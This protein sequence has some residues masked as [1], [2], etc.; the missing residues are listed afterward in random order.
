VRRPLVRASV[1]AVL[2]ALVGGGSTA[3]AMDKTLTVTVDGQDRVLHTYAADVGGAL[4]GAG[5]A[6]APQDRIEPALPTDVVDGDHIIVNRARKLTLVEGGA[7]RSVWTTAASVDEAL[8]GLGVEAAPSH[9]SVAPSATIPLSG[10]SLQLSIPRTVALSDGTAAPT[11]VTTTASTVAGLLAERGIELGPDDVSEPSS[12]SE[13]TDGAHVQ[14]V[15]NGVGEVV[16]VRPIAP[17]EKVVEDPEMPR[18][19]KVV[20]EKGKPGE[21][22]AIMRVQVRNGQEVRR[23]QVRAGGS[24][25]PTPRVVKPTA[26]RRT[27]TATAATTRPPPLTAARRRRRKSPTAPSGTSWP[28]ARPPATGR[29][30]AATATTVA[31]SSTPAPGR[32]TAA[33]STPRCR[34]RPA[35]SSRSRWPAR[36]AT[37][38]AATAPGRPARASSGCRNSPAGSAAGPGRGPRAGR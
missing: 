34:T 6:P 17:P 5:L 38:V 7:E 4:E 32:P 27:P 29:S 21:Q 14:V 35:A 1:L 18:G 19:K 11:Q 37:T 30:T 16:E 15:R 20:V 23:E 33:A 13:L 8:K 31:C 22:T 9:I 12:D 3:L 25:A 28:S 10:M 2:I 36:S 24:T 26:R